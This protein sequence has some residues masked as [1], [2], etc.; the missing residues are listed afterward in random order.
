MRLAPVPLFYVERPQDAIERSGESSRTTHGAASAID[1][2]RYFGGLIVGA[3]LGVTKD[4]LLSDRYY[5][6]HSI[7]ARMT[8]CGRSTKSH[9]AHSSD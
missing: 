3:V 1:A 8:L 9:L 5:Q 7:G 4:E 6:C 2:C